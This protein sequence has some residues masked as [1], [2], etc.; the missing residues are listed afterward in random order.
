MKSK[1][2]YVAP[3]VFRVDLNPEQAIL[4]T[5]SAGATSLIGTGNARCK[6]VQAGLPAGC[7]NASNSG[8]GSAN[9]GARTS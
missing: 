3:E 7:K 2:T 4:S 1:H 8:T 6:P 9:S 5:C